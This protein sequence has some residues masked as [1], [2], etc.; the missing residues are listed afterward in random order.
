MIFDANKR[1][2]VRSLIEVHETEYGG[3]D[4]TEYVDALEKVARAAIKVWK[5]SDML[6]RTHSVQRLHAELYDAL[7][8]VDFMEEHE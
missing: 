5:A 7:K 2:S 8:I 6:G 3:S 1:W 4:I